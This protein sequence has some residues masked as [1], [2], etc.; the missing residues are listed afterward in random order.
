VVFGEDHLRRILTAYA[1]YFNE[2]RTHLSFDKDSPNR[3]PI[4]NV[5]PIVA[6]PILGGLHHH[7]CRI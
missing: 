3:R 6:R 5:G 4:K 2:V 7:Y 1:G